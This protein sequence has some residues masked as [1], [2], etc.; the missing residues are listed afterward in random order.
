MSKWE[1][2]KEQVMA[3]QSDDNIDYEML[4]RWLTRNGYTGKHGGGSHYIFR[5]TGSEMINLQPT[6][7]GQ[8]KGY[9]VKQIREIFRTNEKGKK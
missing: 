2:F 7:A 9:Q 1:K 3:G 5:K 4:C 6:K 8:A